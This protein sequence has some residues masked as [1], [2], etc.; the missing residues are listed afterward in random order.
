MFGYTMGVGVAHR[1]AHRPMATPT[2]MLVMISN[3]D[4]TWGVCI[5]LNLG[6]KLCHWHQVLTSKPKGMRLTRGCEAV[7][8]C[9][10]PQGVSLDITHTSKHLQDILKYILHSRNP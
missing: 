5:L 9:W 2:T 3:A 10:G 7:L 1:H 6:V 4:A 8:M